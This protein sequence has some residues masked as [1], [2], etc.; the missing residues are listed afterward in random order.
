VFDI[1]DILIY[2]IVHNAPFVIK[3]Q[4]KNAVAHEFI[5]SNIIFL[6]RKQCAGLDWSLTTN[7]CRQIEVDDVREFR[8]DR[9]VVEPSEL[10]GVLMITLPSPASF[11]SGHDSF[12]AAEA[13]LPAII[14]HSPSVTI[15]LDQR[16]SLM[17]TF[18]PQFVIC[19]AN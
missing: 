16:L 1:T 5:C 19:S 8:L 12:F 3:M 2:F 15:N 7:A 17:Y 14:R 10:P 4:T 6:L 11:V 9:E 13:L 18:M